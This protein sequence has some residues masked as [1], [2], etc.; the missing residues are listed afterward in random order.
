VAKTDQAELITRK[1]YYS[2]L[3]SALQNAE[4]LLQRKVNPLFLSV[5]DWKR[6]ASQKDSFTNKVKAQTKLFILGSEEAIEA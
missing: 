5:K 6:K 2:D 4:S 3:Y 1:W